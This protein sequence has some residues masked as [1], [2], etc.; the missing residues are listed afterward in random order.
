MPEIVLLNHRSFIDLSSPIFLHPEFTAHAA[1][2]LKNEFD[3]R[4]A[5]K[6][7]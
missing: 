2:G 5:K 1:V 6:R 3:S 7:L 4:R